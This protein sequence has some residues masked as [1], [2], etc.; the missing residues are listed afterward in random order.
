M[1]DTRMWQ[2]DLTQVSVDLVGEFGTY[3]LEPLCEVLDRL[4]G[5]KE[6]V[7]VDLPGVTFLGLRCA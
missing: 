3:G 5:S 7:C 4:L 2:P 1:S 6:T